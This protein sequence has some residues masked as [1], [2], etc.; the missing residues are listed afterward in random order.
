MS[1]LNEKI[2][3]RENSNT[4]GHNENYDQN[5]SYYV[6]TLIKFKKRPSWI[7]ILTW[8]RL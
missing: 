5:E 7:Y 6:S 3:K 1:N 4:Y 2:D 8:E